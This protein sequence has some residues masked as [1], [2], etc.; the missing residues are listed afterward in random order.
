MNDE[1]SGD[2][3]YI[4]ELQDALRWAL[5]VIGEEHTR[6]SRPAL[7]TSGSGYCARCFEVGDCDH[8]A[9]YESARAL[10]SG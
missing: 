3:E 7:D 8:R 9:E 1:E 6:L 10:V 2:D 4:H 5:D